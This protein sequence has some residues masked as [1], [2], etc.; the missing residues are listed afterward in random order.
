VLG[1]R[2]DGGLDHLLLDEVQDTAP[3]QWRIAPALTEEFVF[4]PMVSGQMESLP[5]E[6][7]KQPPTLYK[8]FGRTIVQPVVSS[9][10]VAWPTREGVAAFHPPDVSVP[11]DWPLERTRLDL[12]LAW[13]ID[14]TDIVNMRVRFYN[15]PYEHRVHLSWSF[16]LCI[17]A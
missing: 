13:S 3:E 8:S 17:I 16:L 14:L 10:S 12:D 5:L 6:Q 15:L 11:A 4:V 2:L 7:L 9:S 1:H